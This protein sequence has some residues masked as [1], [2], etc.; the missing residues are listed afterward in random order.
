MHTHTLDANDFIGVDGLVF[1]SVCAGVCAGDVVYLY[2]FL[3]AGRP[4]RTLV[5]FLEHAAV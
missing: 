4:T 5:K 1:I 3:F 2:I